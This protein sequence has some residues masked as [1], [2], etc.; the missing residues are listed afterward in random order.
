MRFFLT[1]IL[2]TLLLASS[3]MATDAPLLP[4]AFAGWQQESGT[5][6]TSTNPADADASNVSVLKEFGFAELQSAN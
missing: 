3:L 4:K 5:L 6:Y 2:S 1:T